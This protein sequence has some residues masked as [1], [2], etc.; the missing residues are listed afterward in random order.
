M[1]GDD[2]RLRGCG[3]YS[4]HKIAKGG[5]RRYKKGEEVRG[6]NNRRGWIKGAYVGHVVK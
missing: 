2:V 1:R 4:R 3:R 6:G 5:G